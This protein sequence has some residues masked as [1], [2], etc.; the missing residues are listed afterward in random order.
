MRFIYKRNV[1]ID[2]LF[3]QSDLMINNEMTDKDKS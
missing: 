3:S 2:G 1:G